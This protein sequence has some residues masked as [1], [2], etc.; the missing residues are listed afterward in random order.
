[1]ELQFKQTP[2]HCLRRAAR[3]VQSTELTQELRLGEGMPDIGRIIA[4]WGQVIL[5]SKEW[6][7]AVATASGG[8]MVWVLYAPED[9]SDC[10]CVDSW[11]PFSLKWDLPETEQE[12]A[13]QVST[14]LRYVDARSLS[15]RKMMIRAD[16]EALGDILYPTQVQ[17][18]RPE[19]VPP[20]VELLRKTYPMLLPREAG[21]KTFVLDEDLPLPA[22]APEKLLCYTI[23][24]EITEKKIMAGKA[25]FR[26]NG[27]LHLLYRCGDGAL[28]TAD[29]ELPFS[30]LQDLE[31]DFDG[32]ALLC[33]ELATTSL[34]L[35][36]ENDRLRLKCGMV[37]QY[38]VEGCCMVE[39]TEDA[40]S[41]DRPVEI[42]E[43]LLQLPAVLD[44]RRETI[45][46]EQ[47]IPGQQGRVVDVTF[48][49]E[50][51]RQRREG[52]EI[53]LELPGQFQVLFYAEDGTLQG[54][55]ARWEG[56]K[57]MGAGEKSFLHG[58]TA[59]LGRPAAGVGG[60]GLE[61]RGQIRLT[62]TTTSD[63]GIPMVTG[64]ELGEIQPQDP[65]RPSLIL[66]RSNGDLWAIAKRCGST[67]A[68]I[69]QANGLE[70]EPETERMLLIP[71]R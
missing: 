30:Q 53:V 12:G 17:I 56:Q 51:P 6:R 57:R 18:A 42:K 61:L 58:Q 48:L 66:C 33:G 24:P 4:C 32:E 25:V 22:P 10:R 21:E 9:G 29:F 36:L 13:V 67:V 7:S 41:P 63:Q 50:F 19:E 52:D 44:Q 26:G 46:A 65:D 70:G 39:V 54:A 38:V 37:V 71:V 40:Y 35:D 34:E 27:N 31:G 8:V 60:E 1:M 43:E 20:D 47:T 5:R 14:L 28:A 55:T 68:A 3:E 62:T 59:P 15:A 49:P 64:L 11:L 69:R 45:G 23:Q 2:C 16:V